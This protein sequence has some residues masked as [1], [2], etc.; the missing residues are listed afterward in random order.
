MEHWVLPELYCPFPSTINP[1][2]ASVEQRTLAWAD[3]QGLL[4]DPHTRKRLERAQIG[5]LIARTHPE[6]AGDVLQLLTD[7]YTWLFLQD[8]ECDETE[9]GR[10]PVALAELHNRFLAVLK[11]ERLRKTDRPLTRALHDIR[12]R[13]GNRVHSHWMERFLRSVQAT[14]DACVW[15]AENRASGTVPSVEEYLA[16]RPYTGGL[17]TLVDMVEV[18]DHLNL[19]FSVYDHPYMQALTRHAVNAICFANDVLSVQKELE[20][21]DVH[22][23]VVILHH[24][25]LSFQEAINRV[26]ALHNAEVRAFIAREQTTPSFSARNDLGIQKYITILKAWMRG[27]LDWSAMTGRYHLPQTTVKE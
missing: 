15:E 19:P 21:N 26:A 17:N 6:G 1:Y 18:T 9:L 13:L 25:E 3:Q 20:Q 24:H 10:D 22:N 11:G 5:G 14:F 12:A 8:D 7:W 23:L 2:T 16:K 4:T 27:N